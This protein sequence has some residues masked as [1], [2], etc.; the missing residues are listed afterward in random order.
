MS[1]VMKLGTPS[2]GTCAGIQ[3]VLSSPSMAFSGPKGLPGL[4]RCH[5]LLPGS[6]R[7]PDVILN[8]NDVS[9]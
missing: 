7:I 1:S 9:C 8:D 2:C 3:K 5:T 4:G 6:L